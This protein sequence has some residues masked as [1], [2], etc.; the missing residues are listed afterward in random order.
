MYF[1]KFFWGVVHYKSVIEVFAGLSHHVE[2]IRRDYI[3]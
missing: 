2:K 1:Y 3:Y